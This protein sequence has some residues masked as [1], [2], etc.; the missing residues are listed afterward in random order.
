MRAFCEAKE[1][2]NVPWEGW[3]DT[4]NENFVPAHVRSQLMT[5]FDTF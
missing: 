3:V 2:D 5:E 1:L 4:L